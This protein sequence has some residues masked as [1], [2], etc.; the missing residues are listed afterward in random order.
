MLAT[1]VLFPGIILWDLC[2][3]P[4]S[5]LLLAGT[6]ANVEGQVI[7]YNWMTAFYPSL[8]FSNHC[9]FCFKEGVLHL[10]W[11]SILR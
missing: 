6:S 9:K 7:K 2:L 1:Q 8:F 4:L 11:L 5:Y 10:I 3:V